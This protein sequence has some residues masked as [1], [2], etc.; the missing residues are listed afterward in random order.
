MRPEVIR[1]HARKRPSPPSHRR[2]HGLNDHYFSHSFPPSL[3]N[4]ILADTSADSSVG[5]QHTNSPDWP[6]VNGHHWNSEGFSISRVLRPY[7]ARSNT[8]REKS[9]NATGLRKP[10]SGTPSVRAEPLE[11]SARPS[12]RNR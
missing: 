6:T 9:I 1:V 12:R 8:P 3:S 11:A 7:P 10:R 4:P 5:A 2:P